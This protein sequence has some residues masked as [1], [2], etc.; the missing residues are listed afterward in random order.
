MAFEKKKFVILGIDCAACAT[1]I[2]HGVKRLEG[3]KSALLNYVKS[4]LEVEFDP[5]KLK[6][7]IPTFIKKLGYDVV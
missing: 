6:E 4:T 7:P 1:G 3:V 2:E 5:K